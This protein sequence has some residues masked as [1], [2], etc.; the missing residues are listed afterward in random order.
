MIID[1]IHI[2]EYCQKEGI[3][4][5]ILRQC[6]IEKMN[7]KGMN[8]KFVFVLDKED[9]PEIPEGSCGLEFDLDTQPDVVLVVEADD[10]GN[11]T[12]EQFPQTHRILL[13]KSN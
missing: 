3:D 1:N 12:F 10:E 11:I 2:L 7:I 5:S 13:N 9:A 8:E 4:L 6:N